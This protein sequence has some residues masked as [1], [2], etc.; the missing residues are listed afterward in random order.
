MGTP[1]H[2]T[3]SLSTNPC[4]MPTVA[5]SAHQSSSGGHGLGY[6]QPLLNHSLVAQPPRRGAEILATQ[7]IRAYFSR[8]EQKPRTRGTA[9]KRRSRSAKNYR[10]ST[11]IKSPSSNLNVEMT[12]F[13]FG[14]TGHCL[15]EASL[16]LSPLGAFIPAGPCPPV[17]GITRN[18]TFFH[19]VGQRAQ[20]IWTDPSLLIFP[21]PEANATL[22]IE[23]LHESAVGASSILC[24]GA[25]SASSNPWG[26]R[27]Q[28]G[29]MAP[30]ITQAL[31]P[32]GDTSSVWPCVSN[33]IMSVPSAEEAAQDIR[34]MEAC[35]QDVFNPFKSPVIPSYRSQASISSHHLSLGQCATGLPYSA[36]YEAQR[37]LCVP[38]VLLPIEG[39]NTV[40]QCMTNSNASVPFAEGKVQDI[41]QSEARQSNALDLFECPAIPSD[42]SQRTI[43]STNMSLGQWC[44][45]CPGSTRPSDALWGGTSGALRASVDQDS[46]GPTRRHRALEVS[47]GLPS[48]ATA[49]GRV[50]TDFHELPALTA[51]ETRSFVGSLPPVA[52]VL[53]R[54]SPPG[55][56]ESGVASPP[57]SPWKRGKTISVLKFPTYAGYDLNPSVAERSV[58]HSSARQQNFCNGEDSCSSMPSNANSRRP[59]PQEALT[60]VST[61]RLL[62][63]LSEW[64]IMPSEFRLP[65]RSEEKPVITPF[66]TL[67]SPSIMATP[68]R[69]EPASLTR[70][71]SGSHR[72]LGLSWKLM[73]GH[74][75]FVLLS[76]LNSS[77]SSREFHCPL[78]EMVNKLMLPGPRMLNCAISLSTSNQQ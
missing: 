49:S 70:Q 8:T 1:Q 23:G 48:W 28:G 62:G 72:R 75:D 12:D 78:L 17:S 64:L 9:P 47:T 67:P 3:Q 40:W 46:Y 77:D 65:G 16:S 26:H 71:T 58:N 50:P 24:P 37:R 22:G 73:V 43:P 52:S 45:G 29:S 38:N 69:D 54:A 34:Q 2:A 63:Y 61:P 39:T 33:M 32:V 42:N 18:D 19:S 5:T 76:P 4:W 31:P 6:N 60:P 57:P 20:E 7:R 14:S 53:P 41:R 21:Y 51:V 68:L 59:L 13:E 66:L 74:Q 44:T 11:K 55:D 10:K 25:S 36:R 56:G 35:Q 15:P 27:S 30:R